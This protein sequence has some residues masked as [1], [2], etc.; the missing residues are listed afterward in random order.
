MQNLNINSI[1]RTMQ[2]Q[3][4]D[5]D[6][7]LYAFRAIIEDA[8]FFR[9]YKLDDF[10]EEFGYTEN[11]ELIQNGERIY[12]QM[13]ETYRKLH[14]NINFDDVIDILDNLEIQ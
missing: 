11:I 10:L 12:K 4:L 9:D 6:D 8:R 5:T 1:T 7:L 13:E 3:T 14:G 2:K